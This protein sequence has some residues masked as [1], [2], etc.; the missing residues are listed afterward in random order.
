MLGNK[1]DFSSCVIW[2]GFHKSSHILY[3]F[4]ESETCYYVYFF[5]FLVTRA[6]PFAEDIK[7]NDTGKCYR[8]YTACDGYSLCNN[9]YDEANCGNENYA[10]II[11]SFNPKHPAKLHLC[12]PKNVLHVY[13]RSLKS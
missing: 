12:M 1:I 2:I 6:C 7:C 8:S 4:N 10:L 13:S 5:L 3:A 9:G 11:C